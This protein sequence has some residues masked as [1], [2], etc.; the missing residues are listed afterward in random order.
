MVYY[1]TT[2]SLVIRYTDVTMELATTPDKVIKYVVA[3]HTSCTM[4]YMNA[5]HYFHDMSH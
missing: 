3:A 2:S 4:K 5:R 1:S